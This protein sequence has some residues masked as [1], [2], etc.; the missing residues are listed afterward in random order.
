MKNIIIVADSLGIGGIEKSLLNMLNIFDYK[1]YNVDLRLYEREGELFKKVDSKVNILEKKK[2]LEC[3][4][5]PIFSLL[6][7]KKYRIM[8]GRL[9]AKFKAI[10]LAKIKGINEISYYQIQN[11][12]KFTHKYLEKE[13]K[14]YDVAIGYVWPHDYIISN[15]DAKIKIGWIHT[16]YKNIY[17]DRKLDFKMW[18]KLDVIVA[19]SK[20]CKR[21]FLE[22]YP[23]LKKKVVVIENITSTR[24]IREDSLKEENLYN[25]EY[26]NIL[27]IG[28]L[29]NAK[30]FDIAIDI[31]EEVKKRGYKKIRWN[32]IGFGPDK[33][34]II[35]L[36]N[37]KNLKENFVLIGKKINPYP[38]LRECDLYIQPSRYE[39]KAVTVTEAKVL[40]KPILISNYE[41]AKSQ[42]NHMKDGI[43]EELDIKKM[44]D[45]IIKLYKDEKLREKLSKGCRLLSYENNYEIDKLYKIIRG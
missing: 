43:I 33:E 45:S 17:L 24:W 10:I 30:G 3:F 37:N 6:K 1:K 26:F 12:Y 27:S 7:E 14:S 34:K 20:D 42:I 16:D 15:V 40:E 36:V 29:C 18:S 9:K 38:Y 23:E 41:T 5:K 13:E 25:K 8:I 32:I 22:I 39:G 35:K 28:R 2:S 19:V 11:A 31:L 4:S 21:A 44:A